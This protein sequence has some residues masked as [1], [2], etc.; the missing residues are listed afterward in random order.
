MNLFRAYIGALRLVR[1]FP[2]PLIFLLA[3]ALT[4]GAPREAFALTWTQRTGAPAESLIG[5]AASADGSR[6]VIGAYGG[7]QAV[8]R[9]TNNGVNWN[10]VLTAASS[11]DHPWGGFAMSSDGTLIIGVQTDGF[12]WR[13]TNSGLTWTQVGPVSEDNWY[14]VSMTPDD[15]C[16]AAVAPGSGTVELSSD[17][18]ATW[19]PSA[20]I[21]A[22]QWDTV[23]YSPN[24]DYLAIGAA[25]ASAHVALSTDQGASWDE[26]V[27]PATP[28]Y[29]IA[30]ANDGTMV[31]GGDNLYVSTDAGATWTDTGLDDT[32]SWNGA[33]I[34]PDGMKMLVSTDNGHV[35]YSND[36]GETWKMQDIGVRS[37]LGLAFYNEGD[38]GAAIGDT[39]YFYLFDVVAPD[40]PSLTSATPSGTSVDLVYVAPDDDGG[41]PLSD[42]LIEYSPAGAGTWTEFSDG[43]STATSATVTGLSSGAS[44]DFRV[45]AV[46]S[47]GTSSPS[48]TQTATIAAEVSSTR[49]RRS[50]GSSNVRGRVN[51]LIEMGNAEAAAKLAAQFP[52]LVEAS[53]GMPVRDLTLGSMGEDV[54]SLQTFLMSQGFSIPAGA[55]GYFG[56][57]TQ[58]ALAAY[59]KAHGIMPAAG[60][61]GPITR[62]YISAHP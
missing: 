50:S 42:Y 17:G 51:N 60:Y 35:W 4:V 12:I 38:G 10:Q 19:A 43:V 53:R 24:G 2:S 27:G 54:R 26:E 61:F 37:W 16:A 48:S 11:D 33:A 23:S 46:S 58:S 9:S 1:A 47:A 36:R 34:S 30:V 21:S 22:D 6:F 28:W 18:G 57:Q 8:W 56:A 32:G 41:D 29:A 31:G 55:T 45:S 7:D 40:A 62:A 15:S 39:G 3:L 14:A 52:N 25:G 13:S 44:Y 20:N 49:S 59:Q 5:L